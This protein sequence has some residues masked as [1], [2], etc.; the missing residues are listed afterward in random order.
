MTDGERHFQSWLDKNSWRRDIQRLEKDY[1]SEGSQRPR[2]PAS[3]EAFVGTKGTIW[4]QGRQVGWSI[5]WYGGPTGA[6]REH[7]TTLALSDEFLPLEVTDVVAFL[8][9]VTRNLELLPCRFCGQPCRGEPTCTV[10]QE[11]EL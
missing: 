7:N 5:V 10:C 3:L 4:P 11:L 1:G 2:V 9:R 6:K 8:T